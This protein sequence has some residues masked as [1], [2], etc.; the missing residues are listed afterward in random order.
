MI[1]VMLKKIGKGRKAW[2]IR[3]ILN[4]GDTT[5]SDASIDQIM[6]GIIGAVQEKIGANLAQ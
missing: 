1:F 3:F 4:F 5:P 2:T 6:Q